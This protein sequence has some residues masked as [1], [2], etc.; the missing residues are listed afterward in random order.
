MNYQKK[1]QK[2]L[3]RDIDMYSFMIDDITLYLDTH[4]D[5]KAAI[6]AYKEYRDLRNEALHEYVN[7]YGP[8]NRYDVNVINVWDWIEGPWPWEGDC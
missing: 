5:C 4:P 1:C 3:K 6:S 8:M 7:N 2:E